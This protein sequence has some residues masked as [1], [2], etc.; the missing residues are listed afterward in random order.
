MT[1]K[2]LAEFEAKEH[3]RIAHEDRVHRF[4][5]LFNELI[6]VS[7]S[8]TQP[9]KE[10]FSQALQRL[11]RTEQQAFFR[12][13]FAGIEEYGKEARSDLRNEASVGAAQALSKLAREKNIFFPYV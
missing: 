12:L 6:R 2:E 1:D 3:K 10:A 5:T 8:S 7:E 13:A 9:A 4:E 11:H